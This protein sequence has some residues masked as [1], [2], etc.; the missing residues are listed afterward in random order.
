M[1]RTRN[2]VVVLLV[3][4][5]ALVVLA[6]CGETPQEHDHIYSEVGGNDSVHWAYCI[7]DNAIDLT[8]IGAHAD[9]NGDGRCEICGYYLGA[10]H[11]HNYSAWVSNA[12]SH[13]KSCGEDGAIDTATIGAHIDANNNGICDDCSCE[14]QS[15][16][17][18]DYSAWG[19][20]AGTHWK[21]CPE[22]NA[23]DVSSIGTHPDG[24]NDGV[25]DLCQAT[26][27][28]HTH[29]YTTWAN[30]A[31]SHWKY[32]PTDNA[33]DTTTIGSHADTD[34]NGSC[35]KCGAIVGGSDSGSGT[36][37]VMPSQTYNPS[38]HDNSTLR[39][40]MKEY[41]TTNG[42][43]DPLPLQ[44]TGSYNC[45]VVPVEIGSYA[46]TSAQLDRLKDTFNG[47]SKDTGW[48]SVKTYYQKASYGKLNMTFDIV[49]KYT[50]KNNDS[51]YENYSSSVSIDGQTYTK[52]G[53]V[54]ILEEVMAYLEPLYDLTKYDTDNDGVLDAIWLIYSS[55][56]I[57]S[58]DVD[59][60]Y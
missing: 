42:Y 44:S 13:W 47:T 30:N 17:T 57:T 34:S 10:P 6:A 49:D 48:E 1:K 28:S 59:S 37:S 4:I 32:C 45:L 2:F 40:A 51:Y 27:D 24:N 5:L 52:T 33:I 16:H 21:Y 36:T 38:T 60:I 15:A 12:S 14:L 50:A 8:T 46:I 9:Q 20:N 43:S 22:D 26:V 3:M 55:P 23:I 31:E 25:C 53:D 29:S 39:E 11:V 19:N 7:S 56:V 41:Y 54:A 58:S 18:H 35:D